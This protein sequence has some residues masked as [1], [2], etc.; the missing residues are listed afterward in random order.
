MLTSVSKT[1]PPH[2]FEK[3][4]SIFVPKSWCSLKKKDNHCY[5]SALSQLK[6]CPKPK[7]VAAP[8]APY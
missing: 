5:S 2:K 3:S 7:V 8:F 4:V 6:L 1:T